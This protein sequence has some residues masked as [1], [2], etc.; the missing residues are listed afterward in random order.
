MATTP[1]LVGLQEIMVLFDVAR[2]TVDQWRYRHLL[3][4]PDWTVSGTP[5]W[6]LQTLL[7]WAAETGRPVYPGRLDD[8]DLPPVSAAAG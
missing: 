2:I 1:Q 8:H 4:E 3:P 5:L 6:R 7:A